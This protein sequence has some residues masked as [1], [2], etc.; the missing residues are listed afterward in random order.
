MGLLVHS[1][2]LLSSTAG[3]D[4]MPV[5]KNT[6]LKVCSKIIAKMALPVEGDE[7]NV[8]GPPE[9]CEQYLYRDREGL[10]LN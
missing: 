4:C 1:E 7:M 10:I 5:R 3:F 8:K 6:L 2:A 9:K